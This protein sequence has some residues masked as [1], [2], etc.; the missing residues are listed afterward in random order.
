MFPNARVSDDD[1]PWPWERRWRAAYFPA[2]SD[3][4]S[5]SPEAFAPSAMAVG[6]AA[7]LLV[8]SLWYVEYLQSRTAV[9]PTST[10][11]QG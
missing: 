3:T 2:V 11:A 8:V 6:S 10:E 7:L 5:D 9:V 4:L 1:I